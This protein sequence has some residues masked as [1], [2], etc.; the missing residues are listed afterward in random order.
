MDERIRRISEEVKAGN[1]W[2][3]TTPTEYDRL[4]VLLEPVEMSAKRVCEYILNQKPQFSPYNAFAGYLRFDGTVEGDVFN[5]PGHKAFA[6]MLDN[7][8]CKPLNNLATMEWQHSEGN[9]KKII[10]IGLDGIKEEIKKS[11]AVHKEKDEQLFLNGLERVCDAMIGWA[12]KC[13]DAA[14]AKVQETED[15]QHR[16]NMLRLASTLRKIPQRPAENFYE[17]VQCIYIC[18]GFLPDSIG[19]IDRQLYPFYQK[20]TENGTLTKAEAAAYLQELFLMLQ[21][22]LHITDSRYSRGGESHF[23]VGGYLPDGTDGFTE[24]TRLILESLME[25][26][27]AI[28]QVSLRWTKKTPTEAFRFT[29]DCER[30]DKY[31][32]IAFVNDEV[33][34][35][36]YMENAGYTFEEAVNYSMVGCNEPVMTGGRILGTAQQNILRCMANTF[37]NRT[38][39]IQKAQTFDEFYGI[40][41]SELYKDIAEM[42]RLDTAFTRA[43]ARDCNLVSSIF[44]DGCIETAKSSTAGGATLSTATMDFIGVTSSIDS[45]AIVKQFVFDEKKISMKTLVDALQNNWVGYEALRTEIL[46]RGNFFGNDIDST[47]KLAQRFTTSIYDCLQQPENKHCYG[48][49]Y[50]V[51]NLIGYNEHHKWFGQQTPATP[52][53]RFAGDPMSFGIGQGGNR[54]T[55]GITALLNSVAKYDPTGIMTGPSVTNVLIDEALMKKDSFFEMV[56]LLFET[57][58][59]NGGT[60][61]QLTYVSKEDL[62]AAKAQ[63][64]KYKHLRVR[65]SGFSDFF[66]NLNDAL[67]DE[68]IS[69]TVKK[70]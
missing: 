57:Y 64:E 2:F 45:L 7:F 41:E 58:F 62:I 53:G 34:I 69:R 10:D 32:R 6:Q 31:K 17:A 50:I 28:P 22:K 25:L 16:E 59:R 18:Y 42:I 14:L 54:D 29:M 51:G 24:L 26:D 35:R 47:N 36:S 48:R 8:Y 67:Q 33:R 4:D 1:C 63:P 43:M 30:K 23:C 55:E 40:Y 11:K 39:E 19:L 12:N 44:L 60:H 68:I 65:V 21:A 66:V 9:F 5:R 70:G 20:E 27:C 15:P 38:E 13:A 37:N 3:E 61:F 46:K 56:V 52:D 49:K